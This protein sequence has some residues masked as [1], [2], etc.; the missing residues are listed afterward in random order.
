ML[1]LDPFARNMVKNAITWAKENKLC[2]TN[3]VHGAEEYRI[4]TFEGY[5]HKEQDTT[6][7]RATAEADLKDY[8]IFGVCVHFHGLLLVDVLIH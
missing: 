3:K 5:S 1:Y 7:T 4:S 6:T 2:R 8:S